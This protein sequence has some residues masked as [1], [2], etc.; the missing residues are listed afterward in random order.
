MELSCTGKRRKSYVRKEGSLE[1]SSLIGVYD[2]FF[3]CQIPMTKNARKLIIQAEL[4]RIDI[5]L[6]LGTLPTRF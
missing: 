1:S 3:S 2:M 4:I 5:E 6:H